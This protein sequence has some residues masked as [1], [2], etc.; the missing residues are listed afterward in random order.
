MLVAALAAITLTMSPGCGDSAGDE[1]IDELVADAVG[2][3]GALAGLSSLTVQASGVR[4]VFDEG[5]LPGEAPLDWGHFSSLTHIDM[6]GD[7]LAIDYIR[8]IKAPILGG[9]VTMEAREVID[10]DIGAISGQGSI[11]APEPADNAMLSDR[12]MATR[13]HTLLS[14]PYLLLRQ[15]VTDDS[16]GGGL[17]IRRG[18]DVD[19]DGV[20]YVT[21]IVD[22]ADLPAPVTFFLERQS[23]TLARAE[24]LVNDFLRRDSLLEIHYD[25][26]QLADSPGADQDRKLSFPVNVEMVMAGHV[27]YRETRSSLVVN[28]AQGDDDFALPERVAPEYDS[29][30]ASRGHSSHQYYHTFAAIG[31]PRDGIQTEVTAVPLGDGTYHLLGSHNSLA[32]EQADGIVIVDAP[33]DEIWGQ[34]LIDWAAETFPEKPIS[35]VISTHHHID[36]SAGLRAFVAAGATV[37]LHQAARDFFAD[38]FAAPSTLLPD[39]LEQEPVQATMVTVPADDRLVLDDT[40]RPIHVYP[41]PTPHAE[42][43]VVVHLPGPDILF[44]SDIYNPGAPLNPVENT[45]PL[46]QSIVD[47]QIPVAVIAG[48]HGLTAT[49]D[50]LEA[51][52]TGN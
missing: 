28:Q 6:P 49:L 13:A 18:D 10:G 42:D 34:V 40:E 5:L 41:M 36:H 4:N 19:R 38:V 26:W 51:A 32:V 43:M 22:T 17:A 14:H 16:N 46:Y 8:E 25:D 9:T 44:V 7:R 50:E 23:G 31:S 1:T 20:Q 29:T 48:G 39:Q 35:H 21:A 2:G 33:L 30:L 47:R 15:L 11:F 27:I 12:L 37:V 52:A 3:Q 45:A 24:T